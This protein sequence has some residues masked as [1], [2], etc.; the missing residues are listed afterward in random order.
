MRN[1]N[2]LLINKL[3]EG[4]RAQGIQRHSI[5]GDERFGYGWYYLKALIRIWNGEIDAF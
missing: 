4:G 2:K 1:D 5:I 3:V